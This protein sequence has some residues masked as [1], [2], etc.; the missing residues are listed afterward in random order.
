MKDCNIL[1]DHCLQ[2]GK[3]TAFEACRIVF[4]RVTFRRG[5]GIGS[6][7][8]NMR[9]YQNLELSQSGRYL[10]GNCLNAITVYPI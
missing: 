7:D 2:Q 6:A 5:F 9:I 8:M 10:K 3:E 4:K 1:M